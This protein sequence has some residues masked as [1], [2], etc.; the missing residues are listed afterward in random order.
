M[1]TS[2]T[3]FPWMVFNPKTESYAICAEQTFALRLNPPS[4][5]V[6]FPRPTFKQLGNKYRGTQSLNFDANACS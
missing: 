4:K 6:S 1:F 5:H 2:E 3:H